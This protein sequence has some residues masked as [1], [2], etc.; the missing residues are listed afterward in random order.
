[1]EQ[2]IRQIIGD[3]V[4]IIA[5]LQTEVEKLQEEIKKLNEDKPER[6]KSN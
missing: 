5:N 1:M 6:K 3:Y 4:F 2:K